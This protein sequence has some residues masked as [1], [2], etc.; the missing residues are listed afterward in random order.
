MHKEKWRKIPG[1]P[2]YAVSDCGRVKS[3]KFGI[4]KLRKLRVNRHG[5]HQI[6]LFVNGRRTYICVHRLLWMAFKGPIPTHLQINHKDGQKLNNT[7]RNL[8]L[9]T[10]SENTAHSYRIGTSAPGRGSKGP[11]AILNEEQVKK[12]RAEYVPWVITQAALAKKYGVSPSA[13]GLI[14]R[15]EH[16]RHL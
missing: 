5:Y 16:W 2:D 9:V 14:V 7:L 11:N 13:I 1:F 12:I 4:P 6:N 15:G 8:E 3:F 10:Q